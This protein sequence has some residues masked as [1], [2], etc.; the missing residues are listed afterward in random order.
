MKQPRIHVISPTEEVNDRTLDLDLVPTLEL[1]R[2]INAEDRTV[3]GAVAA[4]LP[5]IA[6]LV[7]VAAARV[8]DGGRV[9]YFGAGTSGRLGVLDA[10]ELAPTFGVSDTVVAHQAGGARAFVTA[11]EDAEDVVDGTDTGDIRSGDVVIGLAASGRTPYVGAALS[12]ARVLGVPTALVTSNPA[13][14]LAEFADYVLVADTGP[15]ALTGSTRLKAGS[16][17]KLILNTFSTALMVRLGHTFGNLMVDLQATNAKLRGRSLDV[18]GQ[19]TGVPRAEAAAALDACGDIK[20][21]VVYLLARRPDPARPG[22]GA[23]TGSATES[24]TGTD[25]GS[26]TGRGVGPSPE[27]CR[28]ALAD[29]GGYVRRALTA[30]AAAPSGRPAPPAPPPADRR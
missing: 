10:A 29:A 18:L 11:V 23:G 4:V 20:T 14:P 6:D 26:G 2:L 27:Q 8:A 17:Q 21:A 15:E 28:T 12:A 19:A 24:E 30:L 7:D 5:R 3:P 1:V 13:A 25:V 22:D 9:H 16:A